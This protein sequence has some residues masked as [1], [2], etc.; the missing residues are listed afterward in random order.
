MAFKIGQQV[1]AYEFLRV[2]GA[3][4]S[5]KVFEV[6]NTVA[7]RNEML[8]LLPR[9]AAGDQEGAE[10]F[11]RE[12]EIRS[13]LSHPNIA[14]FYGVVELDGQ[15]AMTMEMAPGVSLEERLAE[16][17]V[18]M[19][20]ALDIA[21]QTLKALEYAHDHHIV[22]RE[23]TPANLYLGPDGSVK[24]TGFSLARGYADPKL[25]APG[26]VIGNVHYL[27]P[28]QVKGIH[29]FDGRSDLYSLGVVLFE[30]LTGQK[31]F[32]SKSQF[33]II[34]AHVL[35]PPPL[36]TDLR[37]DLPE[38]LSRILLKA[39]EKMPE[40]RFHDARRFRL[41]LEQVQR[42]IRLAEGEDKPFQVRD[43]ID[44]LDEAPVESGIL[45]LPPELR[46]AI[47]R[48]RRSHEGAAAPDKQTSPAEGRPAPLFQGSAAAFGSPPVA[49]AEG[50]QPAAQAGL[51]MRDLVIGG[52]TFCV[53]VA[54]ILILMLNFA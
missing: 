14:E 22:H 26:T 46:D 2:L 5:T 50:P 45:E 19:S 34:Q 23:I 41:G 33:D 21:E 28:E 47:D 35:E 11:E 51:R 12:A 16:G 27:S 9:E 31:P 20:S 36:P 13:K 4:A 48:R 6:R 10:R 1:G 40:D 42:T 3:T 32:D 24:L 15:L 38:E 49:A 53:V 43:P 29:D 44:E 39:L 54:L 30:V 25:T 17:P 7:R 52:V 37:E 8:K 18:S